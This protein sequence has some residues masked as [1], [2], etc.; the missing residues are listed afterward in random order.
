MDLNLDLEKEDSVSDLPL[1]DLTTSLILGAVIDC[2]CEGCFKEAPVIGNV[3]V[4][5]RHQ[6]IEVLA[7]TR[8]H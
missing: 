7:G 5:K 3:A 8:Q 2:C 4:K 6:T 1:W